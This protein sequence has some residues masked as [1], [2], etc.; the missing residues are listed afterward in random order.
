MKRAIEQKDGYRIVKRGSVE[1]RNIPLECPL[2]ETVIFDE[3]DE[4]SISRSTC[5]YE[6]EVEIA[7]P[8]RENWLKGWRPTGSELDG[9]RSRRLS[10]PHN[11]VHI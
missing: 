4:I 2:C 9:L 1:T 11:R 3:L 10:S 8:N 5:C 7:D 6:C